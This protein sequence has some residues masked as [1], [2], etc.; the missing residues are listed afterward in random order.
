MQRKTAEKP[1]LDYAEK[2][3]VRSS[4]VDVLRVPRVPCP[5]SRGPVPAG[6]TVLT[7]TPHK[8]RWR[9]ALTVP[10]QH[11]PQCWLTPLGCREQTAAFI[12]YIKPNPLFF[13]G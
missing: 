3:R 6:I 1:G 12:R 4:W 5:G 11:L 7:E 9:R 8:P 2:N 10:V 13:W